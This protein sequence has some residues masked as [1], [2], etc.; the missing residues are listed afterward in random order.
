[1]PKLLACVGG[2]DLFLNIEL[3]VLNSKVN[4]NGVLVSKG[5]IK[6]FVENQAKYINTPLY[7]DKEALLTNRP[8]GHRF[9]ERKQEFYTEQ[10]GNFTSFSFKEEDGVYYLL[11]NVAVPKRNKNVI[12]KLKELNSNNALL[13]SY[14]M[15]I[16]ETETI[17]GV[18]YITA[19]PGNLLS[20]VAV[21]SNPAVKEARALMVAS[22]QEAKEESESMDKEKER[23]EKEKEAKKKA[24]EK[25]VEE[26]KKQDEDKEKDV[27][28][29]EAED[30]VEEKPQDKVEDEKEQ[31]DEDE[32]KKKKLEAAKEKEQKKAKCNAEEDKEDV[33]E[34]NINLSEVMKELEDLRAAKHELEL[35]KEQERARRHE[36]ERASLVKRAKLVLDEEEIKDMA[37]A[38]DY[39]DTNAINAAIANKAIQVA[40]ELKNKKDVEKEVEVASVSDSLEVEVNQTGFKHI[41]VQR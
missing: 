5:W 35:I 20:G 23:L 10:I 2:N 26:K 41:S 9:D 37:D 19:S 11:G 30:K 25:A 40:L 32:D 7:C 15:D 39:L 21:V 27:P 36:E 24:E 6:Q 28:E 38:F 13:F 12:Q 22:K 16:I 34:E 4:E 29:K 1:M 3:I 31:V 17:N 14:E 18:K 8:L 33:E